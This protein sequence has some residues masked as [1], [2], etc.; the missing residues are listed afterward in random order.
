M[1]LK[2]LQSFSYILLTLFTLLIYSSCEDKPS[3]EDPNMEQ[4]DSFDNKDFCL[5][6]S[7]I[8]SNE[9]W[10]V[11][12]GAYEAEDCEELKVSKGHYRCCYMEISHNEEDFYTGCMELTKKEYDE[13]GDFIDAIEAGTQSFFGTLSKGYDFEFLNCSSE[14]LVVTLTFGFILLLL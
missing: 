2:Y 10:N 1:S 12:T 14:Y 11:S 5:S 13:T 4:E 9:T 6:K 8:T 3:K 7:I